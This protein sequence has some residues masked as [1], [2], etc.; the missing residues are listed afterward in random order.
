MSSLS[1]QQPISLPLQHAKEEHAGPRE[2][3]AA[4][5]KAAISRTTFASQQSS[6]FSSQKRKRDLSSSSSSSSSSP[7]SQIQRRAGSN[8]VRVGGRRLAQIA[9][10]LPESQI[11]ASVDHPGQS[12]RSLIAYRLYNEASVWLAWT[13]SLYRRTPSPF[14]NGT[15]YGGNSSS[16]NVAAVTTTVN[17]AT[18]SSSTVA[19][20]PGSFATVSQGNYLYLQ[21]SSSSGTKS[22][23]ENPFLLSD[24]ISSLPPITPN[25]QERLQNCDID[26][27]LQFFDTEFSPLTAAGKLYHVMVHD[28]LYHADVSSPYAWNALTP[29]PM[30]LIGAAYSSVSETLN[31]LASVYDLPQVSS[32]STASALDNKDEYATFARTVPSNLGDARAIVHYFYELGVFVFGVFYTADDYGLSYY[33]DLLL[34]AQTLSQETNITMQLLSVSYL[35]G[36]PT[37]VS[38]SM[39]QLAEMQVRYIVAIFESDMWMDAVL[40]A[41]DLRIIGVPGYSWFFTD[42]L[43]ALTTDSFSLNRTV[44]EEKIAQALHGSGI[45]LI[46]INPYEPFDQALAEFSNSTQQ[47][48]IFTNQHAE[49]QIQN[50]LD[51]YSFP[52]PSN[53][54][55]AY[56]SYDAF[57]A[58]AIAACE[59]KEDLFNGTELYDQLLRTEFEGVSGHVSFDP[60]TGTRSASDFD[61]RIVNLLISEQRSTTSEIYFTSDVAVLVSHQNETVRYVRPFVYSDSTTIP[62]SPLPPLAVN[63]NL[64]P[65]GVVVLGLIM[66]TLVM[67]MSIA[68]C[69]WTFYWRNKDVVRASQP[70]FL[71]Q[72]CVGTFL[73][74]FSIVFMSFQE[75][76]SQ[77]TLDAACMIGPWLFDIGLVITISAFISKTWRLNKIFNKGNM[78]RRITVR[79]RDV[80]FPFMVLMTVNLALLIAWSVVAPLRWVRVEGNSLDRFGR[81]KDTYGMCKSVD[82]PRAVTAFLITIAGV[83]LL[84][85]F[86]ANYQVYQSRTI[87]TDFSESYYIALTMASLSETAIIGL[88]LLILSS[89]NPTSFFMVKAL[90]ISISALAILLPIF[91]PKYIQRNYIAQGDDVHRRK[92][93]QVSMGNK[94]GRLSLRKMTSSARI[95]LKMGDKN[96]KPKEEPIAVQRNVASWAAGLIDVVGGK[97]N[98]VI[99]AIGERTTQFIDVIDGLPI[100]KVQQPP[101]SDVAS[102]PGLSKITRHRGYHAELRRKQRLSSRPNSAA[103]A[104][105]THIVRN[106]LRS[107]VSTSVPSIGE[108]TRS[109]LHHDWSEH[110]RE[111]TERQVNED[112]GFAGRND[113]TNGS[114]GGRME[115]NVSVG[116]ASAREQMIFLVD[117]DEEEQE[118]DAMVW[119]KTNGTQ[120][121]M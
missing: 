74:G 5:R 25:V 110:T 107:E 112:I 97:T 1:Q 68:W 104:E 49:Q 105:Q 36:G 90:M 26:F 121:C 3:Y 100:S 116:D 43:L 72:L 75:P 31:T 21:N 108:S 35:D 53:S 15:I 60:N 120:I 106:Q 27:T 87:S 85:L 55:Y 113:S 70:I 6:R 50:L 117:E 73:A 81:A 114:H 91:V 63:P 62:P 23:S 67:L 83:N 69:W 38:D 101:S 59:C 30:A 111:P 24:A 17:N 11:I 9:S 57:S 19:I 54:M 20:F 22:N 12:Q 98:R 48:H 103:F 32:S 34:E 93:V 45:I 119:A 80:M 40:A 82:A 88:P 65:T 56:L 58:L 102:Q 89:H 118:Q 37:P 94:S 39:Q 52:A 77:A 109:W 99:D 66:A 46:N 78:L 76:M 10:F 61:H 44:T 42:S 2:K 16:V 84:A 8:I 64:L 95:I 115:T 96:D 47:Q 41:Y 14:N 28:H 33:Q 71:C 7:S 13:Q 79:A 29:L 18:S 51:N 86:V 4:T 92:G